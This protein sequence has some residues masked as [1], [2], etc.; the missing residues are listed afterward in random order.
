MKLNTVNVIELSDEGVP[1]SLASFDESEEGNRE[2]E[3]LFRTLVEE[4]TDLRGEDIETALDDGYAEV[5]GGGHVVITHS[6]AEIS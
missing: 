2:A 4:T 3:A 6:T 1:F 5:P